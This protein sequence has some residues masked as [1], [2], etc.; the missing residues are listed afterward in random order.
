MPVT[1]H[2][3]HSHPVAAR[4]AAHGTVSAMDTSGSDPNRRRLL[5]IIGR[6]DRDR[7]LSL[8]R[9]QRIAFAL[10]NALVD[11]LLDHPDVSDGEVRALAAASPRAWAVV[12]THPR[13]A[14]SPTL[15]DH[16]VAVGEGSD[17][18]LARLL[19][20]LSHHDTTWS[21]HD[22]SHLL[23]DR[24]Q[25]RLVHS[26][27]GDLADR[28][29]AAG[30][31]LYP[32]DFDDVGML[33]DAAAV[34]DPQLLAD[35]AGTVLALAARIDPEAVA[36]LAETVA[37]LVSHLPTSALTLELP[38]WL[39]KPALRR[40]DLPD[41]LRAG[42]VAAHLVAPLADLAT[43]GGPPYPP[44]D[45]ETSRSVYHCH[46]LLTGAERDL[47]A[48]HLT[49]VHLGGRRRWLRE[50]YLAPA[51]LLVTPAGAT[52]MATDD[53][54][55]A[56]VA[57]HLDAAARRAAV[58]RDDLPTD[59]LRDLVCGGRTDPAM[60]AAALAR[61]LTGPAD[62][63]DRDTAEAV[64][65][66]ATRAALAASPALADLPAEAALAAVEAVLRHPS[67]P[68]RVRGGGATAATRLAAAT[69]LPTPA[70]LGLPVDL[71]LSLA[72]EHDELAALL[73]RTHF[74]LDDH[75]SALALALVED[76]SGSIGDLY[77]TAAE[78]SPTA[79]LAS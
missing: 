6:G 63:Q 34:L 75:Q 9:D 16:V 2:P 38:G 66:V 23:P 51:G 54:R 57:G 69:G 35:H 24:L 19:I 7:W 18:H 44:I 46:A 49:Q 67:G 21:V 58:R 33:A 27:L 72:A 29:P 15:A 4:T 11:D 60:A 40:D 22:L 43:A 59:L 41:D 14:A 56:L 55:A 1:S 3:R 36:G 65:T 79:E 68:G 8:P 70:L 5:A 31:V 76:W 42:L 47:V 48:R 37:T 73:E 39:L 62:L 50:H 17:A 13:T 32:A 28:L 53:L 26:V 64:A 78:L 77:R 45:A 30:A 10:D 61:L 71:A 20:R 52:A 12:V 74:A 25:R